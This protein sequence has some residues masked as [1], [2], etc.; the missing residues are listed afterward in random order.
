MGR[1]VPELP[2]S[3]RS[4]GAAKKELGRILSGSLSTQAMLVSLSGE[5]R[6]HSLRKA[7]ENELERNLEHMT[8]FLFAMDDKVNFHRLIALV[9]SAKAS[10][11]SEALEIFKGVLGPRRTDEFVSLFQSSQLGEGESAGLRDLIRSLGEHDCRWILSGLLLACSAND[12]SENE[13]FVSKCLSHGDDLVRETALQVYLRLEADV[14]VVDETCRK[15]SEDSS[16][17]V[18]RLAQDRLALS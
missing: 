9:K 8:A 1:S 12:Y 17:R 13:D 10:V 6:F 5:D 16:I 7:L 14:G 4:H 15:F 11:K 2:G 18:S 3:K